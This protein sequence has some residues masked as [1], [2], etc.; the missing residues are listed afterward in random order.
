MRILKAGVIEGYTPG[1][2]LA[3]IERGIKKGTIPENIEN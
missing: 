3:I 1:K 2:M